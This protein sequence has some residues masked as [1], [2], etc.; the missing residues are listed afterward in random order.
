LHH[1]FKINRAKINFNFKVEYEKIISEEEAMAKAE[2]LSQM[3][4]EKNQTSSSSFHFND[5]YDKSDLSIEID[6]FDES[7]Q[8]CSTSK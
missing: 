2:S 7:I 1:K 4:P 6:C 8:F 3:S 5:L